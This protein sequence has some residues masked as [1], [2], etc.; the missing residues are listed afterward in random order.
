MYARSDFIPWKSE[1]VAQV[2]G[3]GTTASESPLRTVAIFA[4][5]S[6]DPR[7]TAVA[8]FGILGTVVEN[9]LVGE[10]GACFRMTGYGLYGSRAVSL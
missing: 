5:R 4:T 6:S 7:K 3:S 1:G 2:L 8:G 9:L 10:R